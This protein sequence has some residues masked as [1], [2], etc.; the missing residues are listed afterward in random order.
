MKKLLIFLT[1]I[2]NSLAS[3]ESYPEQ[4]E[5]LSKMKPENYSRE[6]N[7]FNVFFDKFIERKN[8]FCKGEISTQ[9]KKKCRVDIYQLKIN[10]LNAIFIARKNY[11]NYLHNKRLQELEEEKQS[12][13]SN[14][15]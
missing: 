11:L 2:N 14:L 7:E 12:I 15:N 6:I 5:K 3:E 13:L 8:F 4:I 1:L 9:E 10:Y